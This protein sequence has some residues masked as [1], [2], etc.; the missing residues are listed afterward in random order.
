MSGE[1]YIVSCP[2]CGVVEGFMPDAD[3]GLYEPAVVA[4]M[5]IEEAVVHTPRGV[6][7][8]I[9]CPRCGAWTG[10]SGVRPA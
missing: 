5:V 9:R 4:D 1:K 3:E 7:T 8:R 10:P 6:T 2:E